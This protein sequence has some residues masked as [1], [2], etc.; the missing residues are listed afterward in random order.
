MNVE[1][2]QK[3]DLM[4]D[5]YSD[6]KAGFKWEANLIKHFSALVHATK[7]KR[8]DIDKLK[9]I[10]QYIKEETSWTSY[11]RGTGEFLIVNLLAFEED[12]K[13]F[14]ENML[15][16]YDK[17][18]EAGFKRSP[19]LP[20]AAYTIVKQVPIDEW[21]YRIQR[22]KK[23]F[24]KMKE[25]HYWLT[26]SDDYVFAAVLA[27]TDFEVEATSKKIE[28]C[29]SFLNK[30]G[31]YKGN[32]LQTLSHILAIGEEDVEEKCSKAVSLYKNLKEVNCKL[33]Y[34]GL[35]TL[36]LLAL[37]TN[38]VSKTVSEIKEVFDY[39][40]DKDGYGFWGIDKNT[41]VIL[42]ATL[43]SDYYVDEIKKG[44]LQITLSNSINAII[45]AQQQAAI[46]AACAAS[47][48]AASSAS[49]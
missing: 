29:Y 25:N 30:E 13:S 34:T 39:I 38:D 44:V 14:F 17:M 20:L 41:K 40:S 35:A 11:F 16:A 37:I 36:G 12:Y 26:S 45:I 28:E 15:N 31:F 21:S 24:D 18:K 22:T 46:A 32:D 10:K 7:D 4:V 49:S 5:N 48:A 6:L 8:V 27:T 42:C 19:Q 33:Q 1:L 9:E 2:K 23:F 43:V 47:A 3:V